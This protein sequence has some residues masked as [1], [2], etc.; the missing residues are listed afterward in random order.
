MPL[1]GLYGL[2]PLSLVGYQLSDALKF[3]LLKFGRQNLSLPLDF[4]LLILLLP[5]IFNSKLRQN[6]RNG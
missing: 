3:A 1:Y 5:S 4:R 6:L 2:D